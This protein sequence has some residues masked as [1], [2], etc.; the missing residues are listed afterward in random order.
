MSSQA[1]SGTP[2]GQLGLGGQPPRALP[3]PLAYLA[4]YYVL[5]FRGFRLRLNSGHWRIDL[6]L[7]DNFNVFASRS[8][9]SWGSLVCDL[10]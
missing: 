4:R 3:I 10:G 9:W 6:T 5:L 8:R 2:N 1:G 7:H